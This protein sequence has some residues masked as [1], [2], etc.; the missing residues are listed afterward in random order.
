MQLF[1]PSSQLFPFYKPNFSFFLSGFGFQNEI[2]D[3]PIG[4]KHTCSLRAT[5]MDTLAL[6]E[7]LVWTL[8]LSRATRV[9]TS[10]MYNCVKQIQKI[11]Y[12]TIHSTWLLQFKTRLSINEYNNPKP[13]D[14]PPFYSNPTSPLFF[15]HLSQFQL[16]FVGSSLIV[17]CD[18]L[19]LKCDL[20]AIQ[21]RDKL[22][23]LHF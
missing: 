2:L 19:E 23:Y 16:F 7:L 14:L 20:Q 1:S 18:V 5:S 12:F 6:C 10:E 22:F 13:G 17:W 15:Y 9:S 8:A 21:L 4:L 11:F 3:K